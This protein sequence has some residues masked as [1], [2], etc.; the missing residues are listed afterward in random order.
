MNIFVDESGTFSASSRRGSWCVVA[1][2]V[3]PERHTAQLEALINDLRDEAS[4]GAET[5]LR[6]LTEARYFDFLRDLSHLDGLAFFVAVDV[7]LHRPSQIEHHRNMQAAKI[8]ENVDR[9][10]YDEGRR[11]IIALAKAIE[12]LPLQ[13]YT[14]LVCQLELFHRVLTRAPVYYVQRD[15]ASLSAFRWRVD[16][17]AKTPTKYERAFRDI[18]AAA[19]QTKSLRDPMIMLEGE[20]YSFFNRFQYAP[21]EAPEYL[22]RDYGIVVDADTNLGKMVYEDF[23]F[24]DSNGSAG[25][26]AA[27]LLAGGLRRLLRGGYERPEVVAAALGA[28]TLQEQYSGPT[29]KLIS[30]D[31]EA[32]VAASLAG[33]L[34]IMGRNAKA[35]LLSKPVHGRSD[36]IAPP[37][38]GH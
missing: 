8:R 31:Q 11:A 26:Q 12:S 37:I 4:A 33:H 15:P 35:M 36:L 28:N 24:A 34:R 10:V 27:D 30:L 29:V 16:Q 14:Q 18:V 38:E 20:D 5:K 2:Y 22:A 1:A 3:I 17:K 6:H 23:Q 7:S 19:L 21:G 9:M 32:G 13:L 25:I